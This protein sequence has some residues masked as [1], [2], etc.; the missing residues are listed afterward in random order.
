MAVNDKRGKRRPFDPLAEKTK[1]GGIE[2]EA[3]RVEDISDRELQESIFKILL[4]ISEK[5]NVLQ[6]DGEGLGVSDLEDDLL[7]QNGTTNL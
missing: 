4:I 6:P 3:L 2:G 5:L 1:F 7:E